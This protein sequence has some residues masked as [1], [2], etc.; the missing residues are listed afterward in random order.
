M[1]MIECIF[2]VDYE[3][4]GNGEGSLKDL[5]YEPAKSLAAIFRR[6]NARFVTF[7][8]VAEL[9][10]MEAYCADDAIERV[11][12]QIREFYEDGFELGLHLHPQWY[13]ARYK[14]GKWLLDYTEYNLCRLSRERIT[15]IVDRSISY[16]RKILDAPDFVPFSFRA[17]NWLFQP[18]RTAARILA[19][20]GIKVDSSVFKGGL[21]YM[22]QLD[23][24]MALE[25][26]YY[27]IFKDRAD[28]PDPGGTLLELPIYTE[29]V[30]PWQLVTGKRVR[31]QRK[32]RSPLSVRMENLYRVLDYLRLWQPLK[33]D[34][35][36]MT[37]EQLNDMFCRIVQEDENDPQTFRPIVAIGHTKDF[38]DSEAIESLFKFLNKQSIN[39]TSF[40]DVYS[41]CIFS[42]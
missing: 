11:K 42:S 35:C 25:N 36:R 24:R 30:R 10:M 32:S 6:W 38:V 19:D 17:G 12:A 39:I 15:K 18:T 28:V 37:S 20:R 41:K 34:F 13:N 21:Q 23:Y 9:E 2:T 31:L 5:V 16:L 4:Y 8:E 22:H 40:I 33:L 1:T 27:W 7:V 29:M 26:G 3:I 14:N